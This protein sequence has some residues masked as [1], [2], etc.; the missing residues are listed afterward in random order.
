MS[1]ETKNELAEQLIDSASVD[2]TKESS[3]EETASGNNQTKKEKKEPKIDKDGR[4]DSRLPLEADLFF[5]IKEIARIRRMSK[6]AL[7]T[8]Y[9]IE[10]YTKDL[11]TH[12]QLLQSKNFSPKYVNA[13]NGIASMLAGNTRAVL[14]EEI[15]EALL[16]DE[17]SGGTSLGSD[18]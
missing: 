11:L 6:I 17:T 16:D 4:I 10:G 5:D 13:L 7:I 12:K 2:E 8:Q 18:D 14:P 1:Q 15:S 3:T 9:V